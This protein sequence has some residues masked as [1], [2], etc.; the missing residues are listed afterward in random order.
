MVKH[1]LNSSSDDFD[2][3]LVGITCPESQY[4]V[5]SLINDAL[6]TDLFLSDYLPFNLKGGKLFRFSLFRYADEELRLDYF[7]IPNTSNFDEAG[8]VINEEADL[9]AGVDV[10]ESVKL[11]KELPKT[12]YFLLLKGE[13][14]N[15]VRFKIMDSLKTISEIVQLQAIEPADL[16]SRRNLIF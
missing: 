12:D 7:F 5:V 10:D 4:R 11:V 9:F 8:N 3:V 16:P 6:G 14:L 13:D 1:I 2:F 15:K